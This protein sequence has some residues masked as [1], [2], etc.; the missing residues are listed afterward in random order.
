MAL[1]E[2]DLAYRTMF[3]ELDQRTLDGSFSTA[4][5][6]SGNF[7]KV[8]VKGRDYWYFNDPQAKPVRRYVGPAEDADIDR[9]VAEFRQIKDDI[10]ARRKMVSTL[11]RDAG[12]SGPERMTGDVVE[13]LERAGLFRLRG[14]LVGTV[15]FQ[16]YS[17]Y[18]GL[19]L[20]GAAMQTGD[21]D[22]AQFH[23]ISAAV[24]DSM[25]P[26]LETL[27]Q[28]DPSFRAIPHMGDGRQSTRFANASTYQVEFLTPN[29]GSDDYSGKPA[30]MPA[31][32]G[33]AAQPLRYLDFL[34]YE[35][36]R[37]TVLH[38]NGVS[39]LVPSPQRYGVH[40]LIVAGARLDDANGQAKRDKDLQQAA[41]LAE[42][43]AQTRRADALAEAFA[44]AWKRGP[45]WREG[46]TRGLG[47]MRDADRTKTLKALHEGLGQIGER[48]E[49]L[50][51]AP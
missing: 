22:F 5:A 36:V 26:M 2:I 13:A 47:L 30:S 17:A 19:R 18:L 23:S 14:V 42:A 51:E 27:Q 20:P 44:E 16:T 10:K 7:V 25:P 4:F 39:V 35:P 15:A 33:A 32:G 37:T 29:R 38:R 21:A 50:P 31:L 46:L 49:G 34:I 11:I 12:L 1:R 6:L 9:R 45:A 43:L 41:A 3:A 8:P 24:G 28:I 48:L 40:K